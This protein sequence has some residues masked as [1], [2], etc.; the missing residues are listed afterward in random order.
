MNK[1]STSQPP[2]FMPDEPFPPYAYV[3]GE[4]PHPKRDRGGHSYGAEFE[5]P[6]P[7]NLEDWRACRDYL[8][9]IDLFNY[10]YY[11][12]A[13]EAWEGLWVACGRRGLTATYLQALISLAAA[14]LKARSG[15]ARGMRANAGKA[16]RR[17]ESVVSHAG[18]HRTRY[19]G[20]DVRALADFATAISKAPQT[21]GTAAGDENLPAFELLLWPE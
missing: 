7:P 1:R 8:Y 17:L 13:H 6:E 5:I 4:T 11:W 12:E 15:S 9:G 19:M 10:G 2:R 14:G 18:S 20:L 3:P 16:A 21:T